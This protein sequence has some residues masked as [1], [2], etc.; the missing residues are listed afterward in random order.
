MESGKL[1]PSPSVFVEHS[2]LVTPA[3]RTPF[4]VLYGIRSKSKQFAQ[5]LRGAAWPSQ[6][7][8]PKDIPGKANSCVH[9][10]R[11]PSRRVYCLVYSTTK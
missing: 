8:P 6:P 11:Y 9:I 1:I 5:S 3:P 7:E 10:H 2:T 4:H